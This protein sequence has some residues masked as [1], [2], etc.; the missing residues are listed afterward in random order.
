M[1]LIQAKRNLNHEKFILIELIVLNQAE[2]F[3]NKVKL[4]TL[5]YMTAVTCEL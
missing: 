4:A 1:N 3:L 2:N 5:H